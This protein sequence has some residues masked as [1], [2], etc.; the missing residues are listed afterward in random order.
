M[1]FKEKLKEIEKTRD[2]F[3]KDYEELKVNDLLDCATIESARINGMKLGR[4]LTAKEIF[5]V[6][7]SR[8]ATNN[9]EFITITFS[10]EGW[11]ELKKGFTQT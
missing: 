4:E 5:E 8:S 11:E 6:L 1:T 9:T 7:E 2:T 3:R 10:I